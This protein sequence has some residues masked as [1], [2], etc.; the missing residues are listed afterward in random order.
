DPLCASKD[1]ITAAAA[2]AHMARLLLAAERPRDALLYIRRLEREWPQV[3]CLDG[4]TGAA[5]V[6]EWLARPEIQRE[7]A[8]EF[9]LPGGL[10]ET[11]RLPPV[12]GTPAGQR[13]FEI[14]VGGERA[15]F[16]YDVNLTVSNRWQDFFARDS[17]GRQFWKLILDAPAQPINIQFNRA[18]ACGHF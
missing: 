8:L 18:Y 9:P 13:S 17:F 2:T 14:P 10:V 3:V 1:A 5:L 15:P 7:Q 12:A 6:A 11:E 4:K 16:F